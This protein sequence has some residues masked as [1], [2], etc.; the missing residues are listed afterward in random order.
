MTCYILASDMVEVSKIIHF[1]QPHL[2][3]KMYHIYIPGLKMNGDRNDPHSSVT[4]SNF[5][6]FFQ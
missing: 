6:F 4:P 3:D 5:C 1:H 2:K